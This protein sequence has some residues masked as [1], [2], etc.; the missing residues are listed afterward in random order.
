MTVKEL[1]VLLASQPDAALVVVDVAPDQDYVSPL[2][3]V[4]IPGCYR[5]ILDGLG[6]LSQEP[7]EATWNAVL[8]L[9]ERVVG[10]R[11][12]ARTEDALPG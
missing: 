8:L 4:L 9:P 2:Q 11:T 5:S 12:L 3:A 6:S 7:P 1:R 10:E